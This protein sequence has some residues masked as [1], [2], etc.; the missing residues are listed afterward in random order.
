MKHL[1]IYFAIIQLILAS[2][3]LKK[4]NFTSNSDI[5]K[6]MDYIY[7]Q[8]QSTQCKKDIPAK[9]FIAG[10]IKGLY[11]SYIHMNIMDDWNTYFSKLLR[12]EA[13]VPDMNMFV[14][15]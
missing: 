1:I 12:T 14:T 3:N 5:T 11:R 4:G 9:P 7:Q 8:L 2:S 10:E 15:S 6:T 13:S